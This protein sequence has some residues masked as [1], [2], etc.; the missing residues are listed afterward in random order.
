[1]L[2]C[3]DANLLRGAR[4]AV[5]AG[6][7][8]DHVAR[9][10]L[11]DVHLERDALHPQLQRL[12]EELPRALWSV[13]AHRL[14]A[15]LQP[16]RA[17]QSDH[18]EEVVRVKMREEDLRQREAHPVAHHLALGALTTLEQESLAFAYQ[19]HSRHIALYGGASST[20]T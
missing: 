14:G 7:R 10:D 1:M 6:A 3:E 13:E 2:G 19:S 11:L 20:R 16:E 18:T 15:R 17:N 12:R 5:A 4:C 9:L 8:S